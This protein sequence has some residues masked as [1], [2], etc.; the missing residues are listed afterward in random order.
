MHPLQRGDLIEQPVV[1]RGAVGRFLRQQLVRVIAEH[2][3]PVG[4]VDNDDAAFC[5]RFAVVF[6]VGGVA[7]GERTAV[8]KEQHRAIFA[9]A[10]GLPDV[11]IERIFAHFFGE[12]VFEADLKRMIADDTR[13]R[14]HNY[15]RIRLHRARRKG[16]ANAH[17]VPACGRLRFFPSKRAHR[18]RGKRDTGVDFDRLVRVIDAGQIALGD[19]D[20][21]GRFGIFNV[22]GRDLLC[23]RAGTFEDYACTQKQQHKQRQ[24]HKKLSFCEHLFMEH[25]GQHKQHNQGRPAPKRVFA[26]L[27]Q[28]RK[29]QQKQQGK[30]N[31]LL[32]HFRFSFHKHLLRLSF[33]L[34]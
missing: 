9:V 2:A 25:K 13:E 24:S 1:A 33:Y 16:I 34:L 15:R 28:R 14:F 10:R 20:N 5:Q 23:R 32:F 31:K 30:D 26:K 6:A 7:A 12:V 27:K 18:R 3:E 11:E 19:L 22:H 29:H 17:T 4:A 21:A 8:D